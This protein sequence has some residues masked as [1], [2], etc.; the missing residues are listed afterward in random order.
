MRKA[1]I[2]ACTLLVVSVAGFAET[3]SPAPLTS[4]ALAAI[5]GEPAGSCDPQPGQAVAAAKRPAALGMEKALCTA[6]ANCESGT[7]YCE[8][9]NSTASC[10]AVDRN[11]VAGQRGYVTCDGVTTF[12]P[13]VCDPCI[14]CA[15]TGDCL[16][17]C[18]CEG[19]TGCFRECR[20]PIDPYK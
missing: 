20:E 19:R 8:G 17:C 4:E 1:W 11:C 18:R 12:C 14:K 3:P 6:T 15:A 10:T 7:V 2:I 16:A 13:T 9:H 5:L